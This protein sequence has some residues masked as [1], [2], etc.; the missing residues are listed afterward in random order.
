MP[1]E[2]KLDTERHLR[3]TTFTGVLTNELV[4]EAFEAAK[5]FDPTMHSVA[6]CSGAERIA[7]TPDGI[8]RL[9]GHFRTSALSGKRRI[10]IV[11]PT[12]VGYGIS[13]IF[14]ALSEDAAPNLRVFRDYNQA[15]E[16]VTTG[17]MS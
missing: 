8:R 9:S 7:L 15:M 11:A 5:A 13:R 12:D 3:I 17:I 6:D 1:F 4:R 16:W 14:A 10:A 2:I